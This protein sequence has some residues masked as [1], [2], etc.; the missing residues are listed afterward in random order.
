MCNNG[1]RAYYTGQTTNLLTKCV[2]NTCKYTTTD[3]LNSPVG[4]VFQEALVGLVLL[5]NVGH[6]IHH[7]NLPFLPS[8][9]GLHAL[10]SVHS[11]RNRLAL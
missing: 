1:A 10:P 6:N 7:Q 11:V 4:L 5:Q 3:S 9:L 2:V 8:H